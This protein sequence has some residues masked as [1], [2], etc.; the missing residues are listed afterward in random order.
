MLAC[1]VVWNNDYVNIARKC[2]CQREGKKSSLHF[3]SSRD[4]RVLK[5]N[6]VIF[7]CFLIL[8]FS[9][10][11]PPTPIAAHCESFKQLSLIFI[12]LFATFC[13]S[14]KKVWHYNREKSFDLSS[15]YHYH[16]RLSSRKNIARREL[17]LSNR[18]KKQLWQFSLLHWRRSSNWIRNSKH[19]ID[20]QK[21]KIKIERE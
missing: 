18:R 21:M 14:V 9:H 5:Q 11:R 15:Y 6:P 2:D 17:V 12:L 16:L 1:R 4:S 20:C 10:S 3:P 19:K 7:S 8:L 13:A